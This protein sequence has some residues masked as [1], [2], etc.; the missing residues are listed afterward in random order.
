MADPIGFQDGIEAARL[1]WNI[2]DPG[3]AWPDKLAA[4]LRELKVGHNEAL[5]RLAALEAQPAVPFP[6]RGSSTS[7]GV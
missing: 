3:K 5:G 2:L 1:N 7:P 4:T 6:F